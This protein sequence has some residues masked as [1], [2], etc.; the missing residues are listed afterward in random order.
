[1]RLIIK[2]FL[3]IG[4]LVYLLENGGIVFATAGFFILMLWK[5]LKFLFKKP[6]YYG[7]F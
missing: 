5:L 7:P 1:M 3:T 2:V 4:I 6:R